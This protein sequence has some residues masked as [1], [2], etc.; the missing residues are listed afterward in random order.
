MLS[1]L[2][3]QLA[4]LKN[5]SGTA[6]A[7]NRKHSQAIGRGVN[8]SVQTGKQAN[9]QSNRFQASLIYE[10]TREAA[11]VPLSTLKTQ[12]ESALVQLNHQHLIA[13]AARL[14]KASSAKAVRSQIV[15][16][17][18]LLASLLLESPKYK[19]DQVVHCL[20][21]LLRAHQ[22]HTAYPIDLLW[23]V[24][25]ASEHP[26]LQ[27]RV[28]ELID[29]AEHPSY[30]WLRPYVATGFPSR[31][32]WSQFVM[33]ESTILKTLCVWSTSRI[34]SHSP[35]FLAFT[36]AILLQGL[37]HL[38]ET[39]EDQIEHM[40]RILVPAVAPKPLE[41]RDSSIASNDAIDLPRWQLVVC[42]A[43]AEAVPLSQALIDFLCT[44]ILASGN[45]TAHSLACVVSILLAR[46][47]PSNMTDE[48]LKFMLEMPSNDTGAGSFIGCPSLS[49]PIASA[50]WKIDGLAEHLRDLNLLVAPLVAS[51]ALR[52]E[53][54]STAL[55]PER[56]RSILALLELEPQLV[57]AFLTTRKLNCEKDLRK[58]FKLPVDEKQKTDSQAYHASV[59]WLLA[60]S[61]PS[62]SAILTRL[63]SRLAVS[64]YEKSLIIRV[65]FANYECLGKEAVRTLAYC[66]DD[67]L[68]ILAACCSRPDV[69][70]DAKES[71]RYISKCGESVERWVVENS[72]AIL[73]AKIPAG[74]EVVVRGC[75]LTIAVSLG[76]SCSQVG[77]AVKQGLYQL[78]SDF[79]VAQTEQL[80]AAQNLVFRQALSIIFETFTN[81]QVVDSITNLSRC[82][83]QIRRTII[84]PLIHSTKLRCVSTQMSVPEEVVLLECAV[85]GRG[86]SEWLVSQV[87]KLPTDICLI[88]ALSLLKIGSDSTRKAIL[89]LLNGQS[90]LGSNN[91]SQSAKDVCIY[92]AGQETA[93]KMGGPSFL[94]SFFAK[95]DHLEFVTNLWVHN[96]LG[97]LDDTKRNHWIATSAAAIHVA[98]A[99]ELVEQAKFP[100]L[101]RWETTGLPLSQH[102]G[103]LPEE[104]QMYVFRM[105]KGVVARKPQIVVSTGPSGKGG[106][107]RSYS[108]GSEDVALLNPYPASMQDLLLK[109]L[110]EYDAT[111][112]HRAVEVIF[113]SKTWQEKVFQ[114]L[115]V[116]QKQM[117]VVAFA[118]FL[119]ERNSDVDAQTAFY[120][121]NLAA[122]E[123][124]LLLT[125]VDDMVGPLSLLVEYIGENAVLFA[126]SN[127][128]CVK[129]ITHLFNN[130][131]DPRWR[132]S[133]VL[134]AMITTLRKLFDIM[135]AAGQKN[136]IKKA[137]L[138]QWST[139][140]ISLFVESTSVYSKSRPGILALLLCMCPLRPSQLVEPI[141]QCVLVCLDDSPEIQV[142]TI[143]EMVMPVY[144]ENLPATRRPT[145]DLYK[146]ILNR[147]SQKKNYS[148]L[149]LAIARS[150]Q[151]IRSTYAS[152]E[153]ALFVLTVIAQSVRDGSDHMATCHEILCSEIH[154]SRRLLVLQECLEHVYTIMIG[155]STTSFKWMTPDRAAE[156]KKEIKANCDL[157]S[158]FA[159]QQVEKQET[160]SLSLP[161]AIL[162]FVNEAL[163]DKDIDGILKGVSVGT[164][165]SPKVLQIWQFTL[166]MDFFA[167]QTF[168]GD[169]TPAKYEENAILSTLNEIRETLQSVLSPRD[170]IS[171]IQTIISSARE[172]EIQSQAFQIFADNAV[173][174]NEMQPDE[175]SL[176]LS[177][178][179]VAV[180]SVKQ[181]GGKEDSHGASVVTQAALVSIE[182]LAR[183]CGPNLKR[184]RCDKKMHRETIN[185]FRNALERCTDIVKT[186]NQNA[187]LVCSGGLC[188]ATLIRVLLSDSVPSLATLLDALVAKLTGE[189]FDGKDFSSAL[190]QVSM[191]R[192]IISVVETMPNF[193][194]SS[195]PLILKVVLST[196]LRQ[197]KEGSVVE[198]LRRLETEFVDGV[199]SRLLLPIMTQSLLAT[200]GR[201]GASD[202]ILRM[203][204]QSTSKASGLCIAGYLPALVASVC[205]ALENQETREAGG[206]V[207]IA[208][209]LKM[210][211][212]QLKNVY[213]QLRDWSSADNMKSR[214]VAFWSISCR[215]AKELRVLFLP[216][217]T[218]VF[219]DLIVALKQVSESEE[220]PQKKRRTTKDITVHREVLSAALAAL[221]Q[222]L[223][224]DSHQGGNW[225]RDNGSNERFESILECLDGLMLH[226]PDLDPLMSCITALGLAAGDDVFWKP[227]NHSVLRICQV[228]G[229]SK[230]VRLGLGCLLELMKSL[231]EE[232]LTLLPEILPILAE[233]LEDANEEIAKL[234]R[235][236]V[237]HAETLTGE[238]LEERL[239]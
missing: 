112:S 128:S 81:D 168:T 1:S 35:K 215:L 185:N 11:D 239:R 50:L 196:S 167:H 176:F 4:A 138:E 49:Q 232:Y 212:P 16:I 27:Q 90:N 39:R 227:L 221:E 109:V 8:F 238:D 193:I 207:L 67:A 131:E 135:V 213:G 83:K 134:Q 222:A 12:Y 102:I 46:Q 141:V 159:S 174:V 184:L 25:A 101:R 75:I 100:L 208:M 77:T 195:L 38:D 93:A 96:T 200:E 203:I 29:W 233:L 199:E 132:E 88:Y 48:Q 32:I 192:P 10:S 42:S 194:S 179:P 92:V 161:V 178:V 201:G 182:Q 70:K 144:L 175:V 218:M 130:I 206:D 78:L 180:E 153:V 45:C 136:V 57:P 237:A 21:Y 158:E 69:A 148:A 7:S 219:P 73:D 133:F 145:I 95:S 224:A 183:A 118:T 60:Q 166:S 5:P 2:Q 3:S 126:N 91:L 98:E 24:V 79:L 62:W 97:R 187:E 108:I 140:L 23:T 63:S 56:N 6:V 142:S 225:L 33:K 87:S 143:L 216:C 17:L 52:H 47:T 186:Q 120:R 113:K 72:A 157:L 80:T 103:K 14:E 165:S 9:T 127:K 22:L 119:C 28:L 160:L 34:G 94:S 71:L 58:Q 205:L 54:D 61:P 210:N 18:S 177:I 68:P 84:S 170:F 146:T 154:P 36:A 124:I 110:A 40:L 31:N 150:L 37:Q 217:F 172:P 64:L 204:H 107:A 129:V 169:E 86:R 202:T 105:M 156:H 231:G 82:S 151:E 43:V 89:K 74:C 229:N 234:A 191:L 117:L 104:I 65:A 235:E 228:E 13:A 164:S 214:Q 114:T 152:T 173:S 106:R 116:D 197:S 155:S 44:R 59:E 53:L 30:L 211:E 230:C 85:S 220:P 41:K 20:E 123:V 189:G 76:A 162:S 188:A 111:V 149:L 171:T 163:L 147:L 209:I 226:A 137:L 99:M 198:S 66:G 15:V 115:Q 122:D 51:L 26:K 223:R 181:L 121:L 55:V 236:V 125:K 19:S 139:C 190:F